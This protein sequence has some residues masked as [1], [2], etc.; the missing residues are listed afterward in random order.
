MATHSVHVPGK[1]HGQRSLVG[2]SPQGCKE[3]GSS[4]EVR[5]I[6]NKEA[7]IQQILIEYL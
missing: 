4:I 5:N 1:F 2:Y 3:I 6:H 7:F